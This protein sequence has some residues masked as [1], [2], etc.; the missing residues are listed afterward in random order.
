MLIPKNKI[1]KFHHKVINVI[2]VSSKKDM[3]DLNE[4]MKE[5]GKS[6]ITY[7]MIEGGSHLNASA[8]KDKVIDKVLIFTAPKIIG[9]GLGA[10]SSLGIKKVDKAI[11]LKNI[12]TRK[13]GKDL[14]V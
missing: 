6:Q 4:L 3:V 1:D 9:N 14:L 11:K 8:I 5:L 13:I 7:I 2:V 12:T 10:I